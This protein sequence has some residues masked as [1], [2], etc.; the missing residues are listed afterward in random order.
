MLLQRCERIL[1]LAEGKTV[2]VIRIQIGDLS[3]IHG[4]P[5][6]GHDRRDRPFV[7]IA[8]LAFPDAK[9]PGSFRERGTKR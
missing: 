2:P 5:D 8:D 6:D 4:M 3:A 1:G 9:W 7:R